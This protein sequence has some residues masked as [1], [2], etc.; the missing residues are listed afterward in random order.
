MQLIPNF[1]HKQ[2]GVVIVVALFIVALVSAMAY[3]LM[4]RLERDTRSTQLLTR[5]IQA[6]FLA[7]GSLAWA[8]DQLQNNVSKSPIDILPIKSKIEEV[9]GYQI[10]STI[11]DA[12]AKYNINKIIVPV[13]PLRFKALV[14]MVLPSVNETEINTLTQAIISWMSPANQ[15]NEFAKYYLSLHP[16]YREAHRE[17]ISTDELLYIKGMKVEYLNALKPYLTALPGDKPLINVL[18]APP[19]VLMILSETMNLASAEALANY[20][21]R[22][23][24]DSVEKFLALD[25]VKNHNISNELI[26]VRSHYFLIETQVKI[27]TQQLTLF[28]LLERQIDGTK[29]NFKI[30]WQSQ[31]LLP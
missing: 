1:Q 15:Q 5:H 11:Y 14:K 24:V 10:Q 31:N 27:E 28:T 26:T 29:A 16:P 22:N 2:Q 20:L 6:E 19:A 8:M 4:S 30:I 13:Q 17:L 7:A 25:I 12:Q 23:P 18:S 21:K 3:Y 9:E